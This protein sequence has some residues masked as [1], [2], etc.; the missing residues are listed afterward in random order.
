[1]FNFRDKKL[2]IC[3]FILL[4][5]IDVAQANFY[6]LKGE[7]I[8][9]CY[10]VSDKGANPVEN[11]YGAKS[12]RVTS[13]S[14][15]PEWVYQLK[16]G[17][18][19]KIRINYDVTHCRPFYIFIQPVTQGKA[20]AT[21]FSS[22]SPVFN[23]GENISGEYIAFT[24]YELKKGAKN[25]DESVSI[26][27]VRIS[28]VD[29]GTS[30]E[31]ASFEVDIRASWTESQTRQVVNN[32]Q[33]ENPMCINDYRWPRKQLSPQSSCGN[34]SDFPPQKGYEVK[35]HID[36]NGDGV[37]ELI[38]EAEYCRKTHNNICYLIY[39]EHDGH[40]QKIFH[41]YN[42][43]EFFEPHNGYAIVGA[44]EYGP[45]YDTYRMGEYDDGKYRTTYL[46]HPCKDK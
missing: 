45:I 14:A 36:L 12:F 33:F 23:P 43:L 22:P 16:M 15:I 35:Q 8:P 4:T 24:G 27:A 46:R 44:M 31:V 13:V 10:E 38:V 25:S 18:P 28:F 41:F 7:K 11:K 34:G 6:F 9:E 42:E 30:H 1:M 20:N 21:N 26:D 5:I 17:D 2:F 3:M 37:C 32:T 39:E 40:F 29:Y 19:L